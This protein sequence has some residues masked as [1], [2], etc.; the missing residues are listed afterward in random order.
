MLEDGVLGFHVVKQS[1]KEGELRLQPRRAVTGRKKS[2][3]P[4]RFRHQDRI[5]C[6]ELELT[7]DP[8]I[9]IYSQL[10]HVQA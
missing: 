4:P 3:R 7:L 2:V 1:T 10:Q 6:D 5:S 9:Y 8:C